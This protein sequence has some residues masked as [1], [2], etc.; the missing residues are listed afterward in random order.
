MTGSTPTPRCVYVACCRAAWPDGPHAYAALPG[1]ARDDVETAVAGGAD[2]GVTCAALH[3]LAAANIP[4]ADPGPRREAVAR[5][6]ARLERNPVVRALDVVTSC[7]WAVRRL[8]DS[9]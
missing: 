3:L 4:A 1:W 9:F 7:I 6:F 8:Y 2:P 5:V